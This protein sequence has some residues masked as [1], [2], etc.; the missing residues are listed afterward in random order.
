[1]SIFDKFKPDSNNIKKVNA[2]K[3]EILILYPIN[4][5][6]HWLILKF[7]QIAKQTRLISDQLAKMMIR[8][9]MTFQK[10]EVLTKILYN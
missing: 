4:K 3:K 10:K 6:I 7:M 1:M 2:I 9:G 5:Y 8:D